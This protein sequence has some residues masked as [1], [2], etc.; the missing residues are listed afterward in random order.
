[1][2]ILRVVSLSLMF[3]T[4][5]YVRDRA[6]TT[7]PRNAIVVTARAT[8][9]FN[10]KLDPLTVADSALTGVL[11][12]MS[13]DKDFTGD[14][15]GT[16]KGEMLT[17]TTAVKNSVGYV[18]VERV[19][20]RLV[21]KRGSFILQH[22]GTMTRGVTALTVTVVPDSG[23]EELVGLTGSMA[24]TITPDGRHSYEFNY[25]LPK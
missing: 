18:A 13:I 1:M 25:S 19:S 2:S 15:E 6:P 22:A 7:A 20:G 5:A 8:G 9:T 11:V 14:L 16:S 23:T 12:R 24:I 4:T 3:G 21:G 10:Q 17:G